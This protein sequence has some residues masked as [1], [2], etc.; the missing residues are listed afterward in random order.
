MVGRLIVWQLGI[1]LHGVV[2]LVGIHSSGDMY[3]GKDSRGL[4]RYTTNRGVV[5]SRACRWCAR[6]GGCGGERDD[7]RRES[8]SDGGFF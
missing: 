5:F 2:L 4:S 8:G 3:S 6:V 1:V 7:T